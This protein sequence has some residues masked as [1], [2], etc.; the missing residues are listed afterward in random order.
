M[1]RWPIIR[2]VRWLVLLCRVNKHYAVW[3]D[4]GYLPV[5]AQ[6]DYDHLDR[7]WRGEA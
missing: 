7:I 2:H 4:L 3:L 5:Y 1:K 6:Q